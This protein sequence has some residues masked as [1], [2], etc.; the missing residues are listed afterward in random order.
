MKPVFLL[1]AL[2]LLAG[3]PL[4]SQDLVRGRVSDA[5]SGDPIAA[6]SIR[7]GEGAE[8]KTDRNG[9]FQLTLPAGRHVL[10][11]EAGQGYKKDSVVVTTPVSSQFRLD[12]VLEPS[13]RDLDAVR[14]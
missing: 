13:S 7:T 12:I 14:I 4:K 5:F 3:A 2:L 1:S 8:I 10:Y 11:V 9:S 6:A